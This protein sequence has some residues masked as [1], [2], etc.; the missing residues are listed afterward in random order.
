[1][2][3]DI[4]AVSPLSDYQLQLTFED[5][6]RGTIDIAH[7][8]RFDGVFAP[9]RDPAFFQQ[10]AI[11]P[12]LGT[13]VWPNG[14]DLDPVVLYAAV[15]AQSSLPQVEK[16][17]STSDLAYSHNFLPELRQHFGDWVQPNLVSARIL[18]QDDYV[19]LEI[20]GQA[21]DRETA[22]RYN[23]FGIKFNTT[24]HQFSPL[25]TPEQNAQIFLANLDNNHLITYTVNLLTPDSQ[26]ARTRQRTA[27]SSVES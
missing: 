18:H 23:L 17:A 3:Q 7:L 20:L 2:L 9:L 4:I 8:I 15:Q 13:I 6:V 11:S 27:L 24:P 25:Y 10:V 1:M 16:Q 14:A 22:E 19:F 21:G 26:E 5:G 12:D